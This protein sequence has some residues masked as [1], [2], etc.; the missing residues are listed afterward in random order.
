MDWKKGTADSV[1]EKRVY[2]SPVFSYYVYVFL[3]D[4]VKQ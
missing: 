3:K 4:T 2:F 1:A